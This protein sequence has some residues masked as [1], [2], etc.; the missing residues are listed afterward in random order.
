VKS[1]IFWILALVPMCFGRS[2]FILDAELR[3]NFG[4]NGP[5]SQFLTHYTYDVNGNRVMQREW[6]GADSMAT[7][8]SSVRYNYDGGGIVTEELLLSGADTLTIVRYAYGGGKLVAVHTLAKNGAVR[9]IDSLIYDGLGRNIEEQHISS[10]GV[11]TYFHRYILNAQGKML[12]DSL[13]ELVTVTYAASQAVLFLYNADS[14]VASEVQW[15]LSGDSWYCIS[16]AFMSYAAGS[17]ISVATHEREGVGTSLTDSI[18][19]AYDADKNRIKEEDY[20]GNQ[21]LTYRIVFTWRDTRPAFVLINEKSDN[22]RVFTLS[23][24]HGRLIIN[25][26]F[27]NRGEISIYDLTGTRLCRIAVDGS[28]TVPLRG[29]IGKGSYMAVFTNGINRQVM[30][31]TTYN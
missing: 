28:G 14:T 29:H 6:V 2:G 25:C 27:R 13:F 18:A 1:S 24:N 22:D 26:A 16:T 10:A 11:K 3:T 23:D 21:T 12:A 20:N 4:D 19:Y 17:L 8:I 30:N 15:R 31:F 7:P 9:F 5:T